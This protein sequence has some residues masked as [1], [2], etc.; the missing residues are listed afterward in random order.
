MRDCKTILVFFTFFY[1]YLCNAQENHF[2]G[3]YSYSTFICNDNTVQ[4]WGDNYYGQLGRTE[5]DG[6]LS[7][8]N[9]IPDVENIVSID[10]GL[11]NFCCALTSS[12]NVLSWGYNFNGELGIG[13]DCPNTCMQTI[14][15]TVLGG[16]TGTKYLENVIG[17]SVGQT[18]AYALLQTGEIV[19]WGNNAYG[20]LGDGT[21][22][23][24]TT[25]VYVK[26]TENEH[27]TNVKMIA[28]GGNHG[29]ALTNDG[30]VYAWGDNQANQLGCGDNENHY[31]PTIVVDKNG[32]KISSIIA[33]DG[34]MFFGL[35]LRSN[36]VM[37]GTGA[38]KGTHLDKNGIHYK[39]S[40][41]ANFI[42]GGETPNYYLENVMAISAGFSHSLALINEDGTN[43]VVSWGDNTFPESEQTSGGQLSIGKTTT[44]HYSPMYVRTN[45]TTKL[46]NVTHIDAGCGVSYLKTNK[47]FYICGSN[48]YGQLGFG[49][50]TDRWFAT[51]MQTTCSSYYEPLY[52]ISGN[53]ET[54]QLQPIANATVYLYCDDHVIDTCITDSSGNFTLTSYE[55]IGKIKVVS[56]QTEFWAGDV[57]DKENALEFIIDADIK[58]V[59]ITF[60]S[61]QTKINAITQETW[62]NAKSITLYTI[63]GKLIQKLQYNEEIQIQ[64]PTI[65]VILYKN[66]KRQTFITNTN[67]E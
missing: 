4:T 35:M 15:D 38:Y 63:D 16:E 11:G 27:F 45:T 55:G 56:D 66:G 17:I 60:P 65:V 26:T 2:S 44:Q 49:D 41:Y 61:E 42:L 10:A 23:D 25:P 37:Y 3:G 64:Q 13:K 14:P 33:I 30:Y 57:P 51:Q 28:A 58:Y 36:N 47:D 29:Y 34:G 40:T 39:T 67:Q 32:N 31:S 52:L 12:G 43:Y 19:A 62:E 7:Y 24:R 20:Q 59:T 6:S 8:P 54:S 22:E 9:T 46:K 18:H 48:T 50:K 53:V 5:L 1:A 21:E